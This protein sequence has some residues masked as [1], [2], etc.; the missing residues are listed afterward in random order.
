MGAALDT[1]RI[2]ALQKMAAARPADARPYFGLALEW[3]KAERWEEAVA[4][5]AEYLERTD[6]EGNAYGRLG[7]ALRKLG[8][9]EE[10]RDAYRRGI[11]AA[12]RHG[13]PTMSAEFEDVLDDWS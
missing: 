5:L 6:D 12:E 4:A 2:E 10:A 8:R 3:E 1:S 11:A 9:E 7:H 13:H